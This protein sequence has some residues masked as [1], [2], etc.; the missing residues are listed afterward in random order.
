M[1]FYGNY[2]FIY[3]IPLLHVVTHALFRTHSVFPTLDW[4]PHLIHLFITRVK[5]SRAGAQL[6]LD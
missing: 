5:Q 3:M 6:L 4:R 1:I 2:L